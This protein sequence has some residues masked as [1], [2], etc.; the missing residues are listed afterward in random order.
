MSRTKTI[1]LSVTEGQLRELDRLAALGGASRSE[2]ARDALARGLEANDTQAS[3][4]TPTSQGVRTW[5]PRRTLSPSEGG[6]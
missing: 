1:G 3:A 2:V 6:R 4:R 5:R